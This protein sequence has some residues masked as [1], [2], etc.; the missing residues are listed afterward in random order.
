[1][2]RQRRTYPM[3][4]G[5][6]HSQMQVYFSDFFSVDRTTVEAYGAFDVSLVASARLSLQVTYY[7]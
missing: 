2:S 6:D 4:H 5:E 3:T 7:T 1:M